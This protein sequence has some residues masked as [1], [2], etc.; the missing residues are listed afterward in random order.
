M[1]FHPCQEGRAVT[2]DKFLAILGHWKQLVTEMGLEEAP[3][4]LSWDLPPNFYF[5]SLLRSHRLGLLPQR[6]PGL[7]RAG[8]EE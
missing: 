3:E 2:P 1:P 4:F 8:A 6:S 5:S 7:R